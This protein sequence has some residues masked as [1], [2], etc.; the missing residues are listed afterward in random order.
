MKSFSLI[1]FLAVLLFSGCS[2][3]FNS[4]NDNR[5]RDKSFVHLFFETEEEC[6]AAQPEP[7]FFINCHQQI[8]F[9]KNN[10]V[11]LMLSDIIWQGTY[12]VDKNVVWL[13]FEDNYE[14][15]EGFLAFEIIKGNSLRRLDN[16]TMWK[17]LE[18]TSIWE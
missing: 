7:D 11:N 3:E 12:Q 2:H 18:G 13:H 1:G 4:E 17:K 16:N 6:L 8:D 10:E 9:M 5:L 14:V 15:P